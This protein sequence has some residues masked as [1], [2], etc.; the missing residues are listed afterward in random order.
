MPML[1]GEGGNAFIRLQEHILRN[2]TDQTIL[3]WDHIDSTSSVGRLERRID[4]ILAE[5]PAEFKN[6]RHPVAEGYD[7]RAT[8]ATAFEMNSEGLRITL[9]MITKDGSDWAILQCSML[10]NLVGP[11]ALQLTEFGKGSRRYHIFG[12]PSDRRLQVVPLELLA[13]ATPTPVILLRL[14]PYDRTPSAFHALQDVRFRVN[15]YNDA[16]DTK[17]LRSWP[18]YPP[19]DETHFRDKKEKA[20]AAQT[21]QD[22]TISLTGAGSKVGGLKLC[23]MVPGL[24]SE[25]IDGDAGGPIWNVVFSAGHLTN[26]SAGYMFRPPA[27]VVTRSSE[28][29]DL[30]ALCERMADLRETARRSSVSLSASGMIVQ[31]S[32]SSIATSPSAASPSYWQVDVRFSVDEYM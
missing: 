15:I 7:P 31:A 13:D 11:L 27:I 16:W 22:V 32:I 1:Y 3:A 17:V 21:P 6:G 23:T 14:R 19:L 12:G 26:S 10:D 28:A 20:F 5:H 8:K 4:R 2:S 24:G 30:S 9:P 18:M 25:T 29:S